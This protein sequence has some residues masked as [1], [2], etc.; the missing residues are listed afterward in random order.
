MRSNLDDLMMITG[1]LLEAV[2]G[3]R[4]CVMLTEWSQFRDLG[5]EGHRHGRGHAT[6]VRER[7]VGLEN[8]T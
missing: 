5:R 7:T 8:L 6:S 3:A 1:T 4:A 2:G